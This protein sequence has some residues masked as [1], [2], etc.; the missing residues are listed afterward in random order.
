MG[1]LSTFY[2]LLTTYR[3]G[4]VRGHGGQN[5]PCLIRVRLGLR[6][7]LRVRVRVRVS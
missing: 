4:D 7:R 3:A 5:A 6:V 1:Q 2:C